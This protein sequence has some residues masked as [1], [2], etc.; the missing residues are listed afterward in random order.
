MNNKVLCGS[1]VLYVVST[2]SQKM[3]ECSG[4]LLLDIILCT[5]KAVDTRAQTVYGYVLCYDLCWCERHVTSSQ[6]SPCSI[7]IVRIL[8]YAGVS[9]RASACRFS[10]RSQHHAMSNG[11]TTTPITPATTSATFNSTLAG[12]GMIG[13]IGI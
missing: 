2:E 10:V 4:K 5:V 3:S 6:V 11:E 12:I 1:I 8:F 9:V 7:H 13:S